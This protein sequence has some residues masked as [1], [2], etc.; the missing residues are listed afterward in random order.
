MHTCYSCKK[1]VADLD[2]IPY[3]EKNREISLVARRGFAEDVT[4]CYTLHRSLGVPYGPSSW[5]VLPN[6]WRAMLLEGMMKL[7]VVEDRAR[8]IGSRIVSFNAIVFA[9]DEFCS[10]ARSTLPPYLGV[11]LAR[12]YLSRRL[13]ALTRKQVARANARRGLNV[14][15]CFEG[16]AQ[17]ELSREQF[18]ALREKHSEALRLAISGYQLKEFLADQIGEKNLQ[19]MLDAG[20]RLRRDYSNCFRKRNIPKPESSQRPWLVGLTK[21]EAFANPGSNIAGLFI[22]TPPRFHF[23][24]SQQV[25][26]QHAMMGETSEQLAASLSLSTWTVK[27]RWRAIYERVADVDKELLPESLAYSVHASSRGAERRRHLLNYLRQHPEE[28]RPYAL[29]KARWRT[30]GEETR[31]EVRTYNSD[32]APNATIR[33]IASCPATVNKRRQR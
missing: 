7:S 9:T 33:L 16:W 4:A 25:L 19:W 1:F 24:R 12:K 32:A 2:K 3:V 23:N 6:M 30:Q 14:L 22:Y 13:P 21:H 10:E 15:L 11:E 29:P 8:P 17:G 31:A 27:K 5:R 26:L 20:S 18:L 28:L